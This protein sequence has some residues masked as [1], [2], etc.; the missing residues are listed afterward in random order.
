[1]ASPSTTPTI[2][3]SASQRPFRIADEQLHADVA[4]EP[5]GVGEPQKHQEGHHDLDDVDVAEDRQ[6]EELAAQHVGDAKQ[7]QRKDAEPGDQGGELLDPVHEAI[8][9]A[10]R[11]SARARMSGR[12][13]PRGPFDFPRSCA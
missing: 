10:E 1:M 11:A 3:N 6:V 5:L 9:G 13:L 12:W 7:H 8:D 2:S 4:A